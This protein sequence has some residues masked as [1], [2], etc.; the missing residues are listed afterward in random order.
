M[1][2]LIISAY[3]HVVL[4]ENANSKHLPNN[5]LTFSLSTIQ[6]L[7]GQHRILILVARNRKEERKKE[8]ERER[9]RGR[10]RERQ[11]ERE[12]DRETERQREKERKRERKYFAI[13]SL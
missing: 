7:K 3:T 1:A 12:R 13:K 9:E 11:R 6:L 5:S 8:R 2:P 4:T 10:E